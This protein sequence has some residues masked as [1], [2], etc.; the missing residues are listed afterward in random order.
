[1]YS[2]AVARVIVVAICMAIFARAAGQQTLL[3]PDVKDW[4][5]FHRE[6]DKH[7]ARWVTT[8]SGWWG[9][10]AKKAGLSPSDVREI[11]LLAGI[12]DDEPS[13]PIVTLRGAGKVDRYLLLTERPDGCLNGA[14]YGKNFLHFKEFWSSGTPSD[15]RDL[16][17]QP[18]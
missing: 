11:R 12:A 13:D 16:C 14:V 18:A 6:N 8:T 2:Q 10:P 5:A 9:S 3:Q 15:S 17:E 7:W 1:M 4:R